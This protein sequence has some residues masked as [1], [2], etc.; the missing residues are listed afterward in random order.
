MSRVNL[1]YDCCEELNTKLDWNTSFKHIMPHL[2]D[3]RI[4]SHKVSDVENVIR[5][6]EWKRLLITAHNTYSALVCICLISIVL[7]VIYKVYNCL[8][9]KVNCVK[10]DTRES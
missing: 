8:K 6:Q 10:A 9:G 3:L 1:A 2:D 5:E 7:F 4:A